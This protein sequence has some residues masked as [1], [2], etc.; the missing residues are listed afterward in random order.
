MQSSSQVLCG[1]GLTGEIVTSIYSPSY[2]NFRIVLAAA[3]PFFQ[4]LFLSPHPSED[5][6][7]VLEIDGVDP[8][9]IISIIEW[10]YTGNLN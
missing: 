6:E 2:V 10:A 1:S 3:I 9:V 7:T 4:G 8:N 5:K